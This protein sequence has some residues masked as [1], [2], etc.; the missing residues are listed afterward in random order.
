LPENIEER[1]PLKGVRFH[2]AGWIS[3]YGKAER[4]VFYNDEED[5]QDAI[6]TP[7]Y[8]VHPRRRPKTETEE[9]FKERV[10]IWE[11]GKPHAVEKKVQGN[12]MTQKYYVEKLC[13][14]L[15]IN[16]GFCKKMVTLLMGCVEQAL[17]RSIRRQEEFATLGI[18]HRALI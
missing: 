2:I 14:R 18:L 13:V 5:A 15:T 4:L 9:E 6:E 10:R 8:P 1:P 12:A 16:R 3:L 11:A 17:R 7:P